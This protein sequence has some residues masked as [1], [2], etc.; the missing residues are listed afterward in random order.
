MIL[1]TI[2]Y[3]KLIRDKIP[4]MIGKD[5]KKAIIRELVDDTQFMTYLGKKLLEESKE[6]HETN[7]IEELADIIEVINSILQIT[8]YTMD[9]LE[10]LREKKLKDRGGFDKRLVLV[11]VIGQ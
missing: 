1:V 9:K 7:D 5:G 11:E 6:F 3:D 8:N 4:E 10:L 2:E